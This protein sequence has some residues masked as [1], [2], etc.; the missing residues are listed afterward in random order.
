MEKSNNKE[1]VKNIADQLDLYVDCGTGLMHRY[2]AS[3]HSLKKLMKIAGKPVIA[4]DIFIKGTD[5]LQKLINGFN[6]KPEKSLAIFA[7]AKIA[8]T[9]KEEG[10][11]GILNSFI[12]LGVKTIILG[13]KMVNA[14]LIAQ[15]KSAGAIPV[16][17]EEVK[18]AKQIIH[19]AKGKNIT[20]VLPK[21][22]ITVAKSDLEK[23]FKGQ[24]VPTK[25]E[26]NIS[27]DR[28][29]LDVGPAT[30]K[31]HSDLV[32]NSEFRMWNGP[33]GV[34]ENPLF[35]EG[36]NNLAT[37]FQNAKSGLCVLGGGDTV[38]ATKKIV[39][40]DTKN[41]KRIVG[42]GAPMKFISEGG[43]LETIELMKN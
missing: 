5:V 42:G 19:K 7:G 38:A 18:L 8:N 33:V 27:S 40:K 30:Q 32:K 26:K 22:Y 36:T 39:P 34:F 2:H 9:A 43:K 28:V 41:T 15:G 14:F 24:S 10:K 21:D 3:N 29:Q 35:A 23:V 17:E 4:G 12:N 37:A 11:I 31:I 16:G 20:L 6:E 1:L 25:I 13:G